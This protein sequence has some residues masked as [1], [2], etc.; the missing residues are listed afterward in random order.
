MASKPFQWEFTPWEA[1]HA[2]DRFRTDR[3]GGA[4]LCHY[5]VSVK[6]EGVFGELHLWATLVCKY[7]TELY[8]DV[9]RRYDLM[10]P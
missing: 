2:V 10:G 4:L 9:T 1:A 8:E 3:C 7:Q 6:G 5:Y